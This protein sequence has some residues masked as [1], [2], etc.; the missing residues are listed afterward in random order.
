MLLP[1]DMTL[2]IPRSYGRFLLS[3]F[4][5]WLAVSQLSQETPTLFGRVGSEH[6]LHGLVTESH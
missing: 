1:T 2:S 4:P 5:K 3:M 6:W